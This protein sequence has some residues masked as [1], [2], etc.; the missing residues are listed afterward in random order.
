[1][2]D[3]ILEIDPSNP[4]TPDSI[5]YEKSV[6]D[7]LRALW[8]TSIGQLLM[9]SLNKAGE[10]LDRPD[11]RGT[12]HPSAAAWPQ[13]PRDYIEC[14]ARRRRPHPLRPLDYNFPNFFIAAD[15]EIARIQ[16]RRGIP[17]RTGLHPNKQVQRRPAIEGRRVQ[18]ARLR[19]GS[20]GR[21]AVLPYEPL[22]KQVAQI[23]EPVFNPWRDQPLLE[24]EWPP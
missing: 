17:R 23:K 1:M 7:Q 5:D 13:Q 4:S 11:R 20:P 12:R 6:V 14:Q 21:A 16:D 24:A 9:G 19:P 22:T 15:A 10:D 3:G 2:G 18:V 8:H